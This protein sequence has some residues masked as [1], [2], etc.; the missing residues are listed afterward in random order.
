VV[1]LFRSC[2]LVLTLFAGACASTPQHEN[3]SSA[4]LSDVDLARFG[5]SGLDSRVS[6]LRDSHSHIVLRSLLSPAMII[7]TVHLTIPAV[8]LGQL[9]SWSGPAILTQ[10]DIEVKGARIVHETR[11]L[12]NPETR[13]LRI[14]VREA[15]GKGLETRSFESLHGL[16]CEVAVVSESKVRRGAFNY[17]RG[18]GWRSFGLS[19]VI[20]ARALQLHSVRTKAQGS[21]E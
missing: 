17:R 14:L 4:G 12:S 20:A 1:I 13:E 9:E 10:R 19:G 21:A 18:Q 15:L 7:E 11:V 8:G 16:L 2:I 3:D 5:Q 6:A